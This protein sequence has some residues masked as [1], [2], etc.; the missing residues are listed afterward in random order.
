MVTQNREDK[1]DI[2]EKT[3]IGDFDTLTN[4]NTGEDRGVYYDYWH[5][6]R[7]SA[8]E[9]HW[10]ERT[11]WTTK[12]ALFALVGQSVAKKD[13][14]IYTTL[15]VYKEADVGLEMLPPVFTTKRYFDAMIHRKFSEKKF[16]IYEQRIGSN[17]FD[18]VVK[19]YTASDKWWTQHSSYDNVNILFAEIDDR[20]AKIVM[21]E[22]ADQSLKGPRVY[23]IFGKLTQSKKHLPD[24]CDFKMEDDLYVLYKKATDGDVIFK[25][26]E[27][28]DFHHAIKEV[29][30]LL[31]DG[32][33]T[34]GEGWIISKNF[35]LRK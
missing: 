9:D 16:T 33:E 30:K 34:T 5:I 17:R 20:S 32:K 18:K 1:G 21:T 12:N 22:L 4:L 29:E 15:K 35:K 2:K 24:H 6:G 14:K 26:T 7:F 23:E 28:Q 10:D 3:D 31:S 11:H 25:A 27:K 19:W 13:A 8:N